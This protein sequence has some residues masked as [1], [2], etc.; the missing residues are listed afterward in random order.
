MFAGVQVMFMAYHSEVL[1]RE[2]DLRKRSA[3]SPHSTQSTQDGVREDNQ[4]GGLRQAGGG[5]HPLFTA[6]AEAALAQVGSDCY[7]WSSGLLLPN[8][9]CCNAAAHDI[10]LPRSCKLLIG[11][12][13]NIS[14]IQGIVMCFDVYECCM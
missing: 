2:R 6:M 3:L 5:G 12:V 4:E 10:D 14:F 9:C 1:Q 13:K 7:S 8:A 11:L